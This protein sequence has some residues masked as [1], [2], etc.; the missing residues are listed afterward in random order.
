LETVA[1]DLRLVP[2]DEVLDFRK[3]HFKAHRTYIRAVRKLTRELSS[4]PEPDREELLETRREEIQDLANGLKTTSRKA[5]KRPA[6]F[7]I[8]MAGAF[9][10][11]LAADKSG[12]HDFVGPLLTAA[13]LLIGLKGAE[14]VN[15]GAY[16][17]LFQA[18][19]RF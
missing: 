1:V 10:K 14:K 18:H 19:T 8:G 13:G 9:W 7:A 16:S 11:F 17:Y 2:L 12:T 5:W 4:L 15:T 6:G 3:E